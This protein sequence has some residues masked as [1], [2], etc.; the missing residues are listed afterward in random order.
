MKIVHVEAGRHL[1]GGALQ[2]VF[3]LRALSGQPGEQH[4]LVC[5]PGA[6]IGQAV[7]ALG[8]RVLELPLGG[9]A[10]PGMAVRIARVLRAERADLVHLHSRRGAD[11]WGALAGRLAGV[12]V[13]LSRRVDNPEP[14]AWVALKYRLTDRVVTISQGIR[15]VLLAEGVPPGKVVCVPSAVDTGHYRPAADPAAAR[16]ALAAEFGLPADVPVIGMAAQFI[17]RK[18]HRL[19]LDALPAVFAQHPDAHFLLFGRG[20]LAGEVQRTLAERRLEG[21]VRLPGF[22]DDL[23]RWL[24]ALDLL[25]HPA[26][27]E[28]LGVTLLQ[29][30][31][32]GVAIVAGRAGGIPEIVRDGDNGRLIDPHDAVALSSA[33][34]ELLADAGLRTRM[35]AAGRAIAEQDFSIAAMVAGNRRV[36]EELLGG[37]EPSGPA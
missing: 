21:R 4:V 27:L 22:R 9:D 32:C 14:R 18:G 13:V 29:A 23:A 10:D 7:R 3:L 25:V 37:A 2:V 11:L 34:N 12:P 6:A 1:Y 19:L 24:P 35:G 31:A 26:A 20:P 33:L 15:R 8:L 36:Y 5:A 28:G 16:A 17:P 30:A